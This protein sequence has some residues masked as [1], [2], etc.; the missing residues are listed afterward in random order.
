[1]QVPPRL[2]S[3]PPRYGASNTKKT[4]LIVLTSVAGV[5]LLCCIGGAVLIWRAGLGDVLACHDLTAKGKYKEAIPHCRAV[6]QQ[7]PRSGA[8]HNELGWSLAL[9]G[10]GPES[11]SECR[12]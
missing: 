4:L 1:M 3:E 9:V 5:F 8:A 10:E 2:Y 12:K 6:V 11:V 7:I